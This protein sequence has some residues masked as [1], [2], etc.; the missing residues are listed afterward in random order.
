[1]II[2]PFM[3]RH[4]EQQH[5]TEDYVSVPPALTITDETGA[6]WTLGFRFGSAPRG[7][8]AFN[9]LRNGQEVGEVAS[10]IERRHG[11]V[12]VFTAQG[13]KWMLTGTVTDAQAPTL[14]QA[15]RARARP[16]R[17]GQGSLRGLHSVECWLG[18]VPLLGFF[19]DPLRDTGGWVGELEAVL[20]CSVGEWLSAT[21]RPLTDRIVVTALLT[22][23]Y[24]REIPVRVGELQGMTT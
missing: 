1:M 14:V 10:R 15:I 16:A 22:S 12:R 4:G 11:R 19:Y 13:W 2:M 7:E 23:G 18:P 6:I 17:E 8:F 9:V 5:V 21:V 24:E 20:A 3:V